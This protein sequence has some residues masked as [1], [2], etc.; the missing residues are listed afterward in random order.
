V[1]HLREF[2]CDV[3]VLDESKNRLKL[4]PKLKKMKFMGFMDRSKSICYYDAAAQSIKVSRNFA[5]NE[6]DKLWELEIYTDV[7]GLQAEGEPE[8]G[9]DFAN[10]ETPNTPIIET[11][12]PTP[13]NTTKPIT[14]TPMRPVREGRKD[15]DYRVINNPRT[16]PS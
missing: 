12:P 3:W 11:Q 1:A 10:P 2:G 14:E 6:N 16:Q 5:F 4:S 9:D 15:L 8:P 7:P 13:D